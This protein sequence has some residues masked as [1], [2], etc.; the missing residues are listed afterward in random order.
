MCDRETIALAEEIRDLHGR[1]C[2]VSARLMGLSVSEDER[3]VKICA[4]R[5]YTIL[6]ELERF[7]NV[8]EQQDALRRAMRD[9][10]VQ[11]RTQFVQIVAWV[12]MFC[13]FMRLQAY[14]TSFPVLGLLALM[15]GGGLIV[16]YGHGRWARTSLR[17]NLRRQLI[18]RGVPICAEC[19]Y[20]LRGQTTPRCPECGREQS[21][22]PEERACPPN[23]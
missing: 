1:A 22:N 13:I 17:R 23:P 10:S 20:D 12:A 16:T 4:A 9:P 5:P 18:E 8:F 15:G 2:A 14:T 21:P 11:W 7:G 3:L 6:P 19:G